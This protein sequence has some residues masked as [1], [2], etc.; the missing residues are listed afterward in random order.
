[1]VKQ[2]DSEEEKKLKKQ[3]KKEKKDA[4]RKRESDVTIE[5][6]LI[7]VKRQE[8][9]DSDDDSDE[10]VPQIKD[11]EPMSLPSPFQ[12]KF[13]SFMLSLPPSS[14]AN[15]SKAYNTC[16]QS[17][18][19]KYSDSLDGVMLSYSNVK[20]DESKNK[21]P[22]GRIID[23]LPHIHVFV[24]CDVLVFTPC[25][26]KQLSGVVSESFPSHIGFLVYELF[27]AMVNSDS[28]MNSGFTFDTD[29]NQ[30]V[31]DESGMSIAEG[32]IVQFTVE[33]LHE[34]EGLISLECKD[35]VTMSIFE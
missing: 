28:L 32:D 26:G 4:K 31:K 10:H 13:V 35:P 20:I 1:M 16:L 23:E 14:M 11:S 12:K 25:V 22:Y 7:K 8:D 17:M 30:W 9:D 2:E 33:K 29:L 21:G 27:N 6:P 3:K 18:L 5:A 24:T 15:M 19:L 34:C